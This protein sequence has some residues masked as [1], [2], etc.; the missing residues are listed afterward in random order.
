MADSMIGMVSWSCPSNI[1]LVKYWGKKGFQLPSNPS[2]SMTLDK[3][4]THMD[5]RFEYDPERTEMSFQ[6]SFEGTTNEKFG[7]KIREYLVRIAPSMP[8]LYHLKID[9]QS[10][11]TFPHSAG[12]A[13]S[14]SAMGALALCLC[15]VEE[16]VSGVI[17]SKQA[18]F[19]QASNLARLA[20]GSASRSVYGGFV[21]WGES[22][23][24]KDSSDEY[25]VQIPFEIN[26]EFNTMHDAILIVNSREKGV[27][28]RA[29]HKLMEGHCYA[30][31][32][33]VQVRDHLQELIEAM[34]SGDFERFVTVVENEA[35]SLHGLMLASNPS[36]LLMAPNTIEIISR[37]RA[38]RE[39]TRIPICFT[40]DAGP[41]VHLLYR[42]ADHI[43]V[44]Q[45]IIG[46]LAQ[47]CEAGRWI[48]D[49]IGKGPVKRDGIPD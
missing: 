24:I 35:L 37:I 2:L 49:G 18:F 17:K 3:S 33:M 8:F 43:E 41:N 38:F 25:A 6:F 13:S 16:Q 7:S 36:F 10:H 19:R 42:D 22:E 34:K 11:N 5:F 46:E 4:V 20:S 1:A 45:F 9:I 26:P 14:A 15:S 31:G 21:A 23:K 40:L 47:F 28:S 32:R 27:S 29:G 39:R 44:K 30:E 48:A 12:I